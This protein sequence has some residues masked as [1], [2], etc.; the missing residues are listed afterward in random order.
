[1]I[2]MYHK[3]D[4]EDHT[5]WWVNVDNF[6][7]QMKEIKSKKVVYLDDYDPKNPQHVVI[8]FDDG[9]TNILQYA[10]PIMEKFNYPF[11]IFIIG[12]Y[13]GKQNS[14]DLNEPITQ[15]CS[16]AD[17]VEIVKRGGRLQWHTKSHLNLG[18]IRDVNLIRSEFNI[19][20]KL[21][22]I[23]PKGFK[24]FA[25]PYGIFS[26][27]VISVVKKKFYGAVSCADGNNYEYQ[28]TRLAV[29][30]DTTFS[31]KNFQLNKKIADLEV[32]LE[33][34]HSTLLNMQNKSYI[35][36]KQKIKQLLLLKN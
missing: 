5:V 15:I 24:W 17:L 32:R 35:N 28:I 12:N 9:Y 16:V 27:E 31:N 2:L 30:N 19:P 6:Y 11:E 21:K 8:T 26:D 1:M 3:V 34:S 13:I 29:K 10:L 7:R 25:Y 4:L 22:K 20:K 33:Q 18:K 14:W 36:F 23:D